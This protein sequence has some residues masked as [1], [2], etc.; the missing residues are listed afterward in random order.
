L[1]G[2][3]EGAA[4]SIAS[5]DLAE[6]ASGLKGQPVIV[7]ICNSLSPLAWD[8]RM[9]EGLRVFAER[10]QPINISC[11][12]MSGAT[13][14]VQLIGNIVEAN[15]EVLGGVVYS[16]LVRP[17]APIIYG[18][19][20][21]VMD[22]GAMGLALGAPEYTLVSAACAQMAARYGLPYRGGGGL[23]DAKVLDGQAMAES[24][25]NL[26]YSLSEGVHFMLQSVG[27]LE[28]FMSFS[29]DKWVADEEVIM[30][31]ARLARGLGDWPGDL[32]ETF[33]QG[34]EA[35]G[36]LKLKSTLKRFRTEFYRPTVGDRRSFEIWRGAGRDYRAEAW[37][38][39]RKRLASYRPPDIAPEAKAAMRAIWAKAGVE[40]D[41]EVP[42]D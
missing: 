30:K 2:Q 35:G 19:T 38:Q 1:V 24:A 33:A 15:A 17:G 11:C 6:A 22:M 5:V 31:L 20:S 21:S 36:Y 16:Q 34:S 7:A 41:Y 12:S 3:S 4:V 9:L 32:M 23:T 42:A 13:S 37:A 29:F 28:S 14:P 10:G 8:E 39:V 27:V 26:V 40:P 25:W 18:T